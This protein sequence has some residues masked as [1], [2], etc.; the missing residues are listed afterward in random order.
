MTYIVG[1]FLPRASQNNLHRISLTGTVH[2][3]HSHA[4]GLA[5]VS[6]TVSRLPLF[7]LRASNCAQFYP[8]YTNTLPPFNQL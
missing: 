5:T 6:Q 4:Q 2:L 3:S 7:C 1:A 8:S